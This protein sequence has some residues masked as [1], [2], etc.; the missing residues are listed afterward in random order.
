MLQL[1]VTFPFRSS[2]LLEGRF[3][4]PLARVPRSSSFGLIWK[5]GANQGF[6]LSMEKYEHFTFTGGTK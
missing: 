2:G 4:K 3:G 6:A 1:R 5:F